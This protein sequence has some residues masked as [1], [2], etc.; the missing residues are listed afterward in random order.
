MIIEIA[1]RF[2]DPESDVPRTAA[3][4]SFVLVLPLLPVMAT[5]LSRSDSSVMRRDLLIGNERVG[6]AEER[7][8]RAEP[9]RSN[10]AST[11]APAAPRFAGFVDKFV[12]VEILPAQRHEQ[13]APAA[14]CANRC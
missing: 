7:K 6:D 1:F 11:I 4:K 3:T 14:A 10:C 12:A 8:I 9:C 13:I 2:R 5:T